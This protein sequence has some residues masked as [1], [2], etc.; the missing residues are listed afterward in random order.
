MLIIIVPREKGEIEDA[1]KCMENLLHDNRYPW[2]MTVE[3]L[4]DGAPELPDF[5]T[6]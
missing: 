5:P 2:N 4:T 6:Y 3:L 1:Y